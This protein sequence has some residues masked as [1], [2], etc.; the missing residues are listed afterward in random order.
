MATSATMVHP[1]QA[2]REAGREPSALREDEALRPL[3]AEIEGRGSRLM[4]ASLD[5]FVRRFYPKHEAIEV[6]ATDAKELPQPE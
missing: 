4:T 2:T 3:L 1:F 5:V 6:M